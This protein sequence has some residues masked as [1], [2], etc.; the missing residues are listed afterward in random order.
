MQD[1]H[2]LLYRHEKSLAEPILDYLAQQTN[3]RLL[4]KTS[5][6]DDDRAATI[7]FVPLKQSSEHL[8]A[9]LQE[10]GIGTEYGDFYAPR[11]LEG[12]GI[13]PASGVVRLSLLHYN[14]PA[15][16]ERVLAEL[17]RALR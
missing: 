16:V 10:A 4:G 9:T 3:I 17:D 8:T 5:V 12:V 7:A 14:T 6:R 1:I 11:L 13:D 2:G 15:D